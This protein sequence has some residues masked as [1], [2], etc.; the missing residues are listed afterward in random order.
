M[1]INKILIAFNITIYILL[2]MCFEAFAETTTN[3]NNET[4]NQNQEITVSVEAP[5]NI[6]TTPEV[7]QEVVAQ[8]ESN[9]IAQ[10]NLSKDTINKLKKNSSNTTQVEIIDEDVPFSATIE[11]DNTSKAV[12]LDN[13]PKTGDFNNNYYYI[14]LICSFSLSCLAVFTKFNLKRNLSKNK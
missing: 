14:I 3:N 4:S 10:A 2:S 7:E 8:D 11:K 9:D 12:P 6:G 5:T 1:K 13:T